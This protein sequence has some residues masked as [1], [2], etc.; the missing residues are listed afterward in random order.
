MDPD[1][2]LEELLAIAGAVVDCDSSDPE[3]VSPETVE[4]QC[5]RMAELAIALDEWI[6]TGGFLP[7]AWRTS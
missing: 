7:T 5:T 1:A 4:G 2:N 3:S 6:R